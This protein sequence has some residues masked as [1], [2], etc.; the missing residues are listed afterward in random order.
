MPHLHFHDLRHTFASRWVMSEGD[1][2]VLKEILGHKSIAMTQRY[3][4]LSPAHK[5]A[6]VDK[7]ESMWARSTQTKSAPVQPQAVPQIFSGHHSVTSAVPATSSS[8][9]CLD[10]RGFEA[11]A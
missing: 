10:G 4:H 1:L 2:C 7:M 11:S 5:R 3:A 6:M 9:E 8:V